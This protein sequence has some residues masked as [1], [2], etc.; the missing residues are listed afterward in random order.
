MKKR[1][2]RRT[3]KVGTGDPRRETKRDDLLALFRRLDT[4]NSGSLSVGELGSLARRMQMKPANLMRAMDRD[5]NRKVNF[6]EF[7]RY[8]RR[9]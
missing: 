1:V 6:S 9:N 8:M 5:G 3:E 7:K 2:K 4:N